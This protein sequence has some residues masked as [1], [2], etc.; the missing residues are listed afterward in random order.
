M[1]DSHLIG[2]GLFNYKNAKAI[3][4]KGEGFRPGEWKIKQE[5]VYE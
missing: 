1:T 4:L 3:R 2:I 5:E